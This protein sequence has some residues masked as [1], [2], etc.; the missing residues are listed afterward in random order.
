MLSAEHQRRLDE[1]ERQLRL[2]DPRF[3][4]RMRRTRRRRRLVLAVAG[5][6]LWALGP[7]L[8]IA[9]LGV[10]AVVLAVTMAPLGAL[11]LVSS[12]KIPK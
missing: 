11:S 9:G 3:V 8:A 5:I 2:S 7:A 4:S 10:A 1:I 12:W 6:L